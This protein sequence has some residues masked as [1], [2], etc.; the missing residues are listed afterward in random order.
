MPY[1]TGNDFSR[2]LGWG[3][4][5][6][7][8][9]L[10]ANLKGLKRLIINWNQSLVESFDIWKVELKLRESGQFYKITNKI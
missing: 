7:S 5:A 8:D 4:S 10:E 3:P 9:L 1:G 2:V 6:P